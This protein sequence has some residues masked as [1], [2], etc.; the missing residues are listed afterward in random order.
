MITVERYS[1]NA[2]DVQYQSHHLSEINNFILDRN[3]FIKRF[4]D[5]CDNQYITKILLEQ[6]DKYHDFYVQNYKD[7]ERGIWVFIEGYKNNQSLNHLKEKVPCFLAE[8]PDDTEVY[9]VNLQEKIL[10]SDSLC[11]CFGCY[12]P[13]RSLANIQNIRRKNDRNLEPTKQIDR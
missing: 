12:V 13:E 11:T 2:F 7:F 3:E 4:V 8:L 10:L 6:Y 1:K 9:D 5:T